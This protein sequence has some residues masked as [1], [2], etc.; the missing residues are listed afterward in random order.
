MADEFDED[1]KRCAVCGRFNCEQPSKCEVK[2]TTDKSR[3][4]IRDELEDII[5]E[6]EAVAAKVKKLRWEMAC[7]EDEK[8][9]IEQSIDNEPRSLLCDNLECDAKLRLAGE[10]KNGEYTHPVL[11]TCGCF[12]DYD[13]TPTA[14]RW[15]P[16]LQHAIELGI[17]TRTFG[18]D[19]VDN[20]CVGEVEMLKEFIYIVPCVFP[21]FSIPFDVTSNFELRFE[22][23]SMPA[24]PLVHCRHQQ[25]SIQCI[26]LI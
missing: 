13:V 19:T 16:I 1:I 23:K 6:Q 12:D 17:P 11:Y 10:H 5:H 2:I 26:C 14:D 20:V 24:I 7:I 22:M 9:K 3:K 15:T 21:G 18:I 4:R 25:N 8:T